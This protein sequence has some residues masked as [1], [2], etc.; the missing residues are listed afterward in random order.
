[1]TEYLPDNNDEAFENIVIGDAIQSG[2]IYI[3]PE[4]KEA[5]R[6]LKYGTPE[7]RLANPILQTLFREAN[8]EALIDEALSDASHDLIEFIEDEL[9]P[10][11]AE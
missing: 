5:A 2:R 8:Q 11:A 3:S 7:E 6:I 9:P 4:A 1:M 10:R